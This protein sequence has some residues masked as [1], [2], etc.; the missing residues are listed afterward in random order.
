V[1][2]VTASSIY[3]RRVAMTNPF[4]TI[5]RLLDGTPDAVS[6]ASGASRRGAGEKDFMKH[7][8]TAD[9]RF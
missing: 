6:T 2:I 4:T 7:D 8:L 5:K 1:T 9:E 3:W